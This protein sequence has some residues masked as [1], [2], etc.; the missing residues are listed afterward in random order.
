MNK[1]LIFFNSHELKLLSYL[2][3]NNLKKIFLVTGKNSFR[4]SGACLFIENLLSLDD[5]LNIY[6]FSDFSPN[7]KLEDAKNGLHFYKKNKC[8]T[9]ISIGGG[10]VMDMAKIIKA[11]S[12]DNVLD[13][14]KLLIT[15]SL[16][17][18]EKSP[19][20]A[21][22]T[23]SGSGS[24]STSFA[25]IYINEI[26]YSIQNKIL[27]PECVLLDYK[28]TLSAN[29]YQ[30]ACSGLDALC[31][32][33]ESYWSVNSTKISKQFSKDAIKIIFENL[34]QAVNNSENIN[35]K[36]KMLLGS[37]Y[38]GKA[39]NISKTTA[40][41]AFS[42][43]LTSK[44]KIPH[45]HAVLL[46]L[47]KFLNYNYFVSET[48]CNDSR[49]PCYVKKTIDDILE[50]FNVKNPNEFIEFIQKFAL[51]IG[52]E[53]NMNNLAI[54]KDMIKNDLNVNVQRLSNNPRLLENKNYTDFFIW[55]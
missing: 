13:I 54:S 30:I 37:N 40:P 50:I 2:Q 6:Q 18:S 45:G 20:I 51:N 38:A 42:Y 31:Q 32:A 16:N 8:D 44:F 52:V 23:T 27:L 55:K 28:L 48:N 36:K 41:H 10:S 46:S 26:K 34:E 49:G 11:I 3:K 9:I 4:K 29:P 15:N 22:P 7:P 14:E 25:V 24:E 53:L 5:T 21:I 17:F 1:Q 19:L 47:P 39:I 35:A 12:N 43:S 33:I